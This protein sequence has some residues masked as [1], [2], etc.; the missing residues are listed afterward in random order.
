[1]RKEWTKE[2]DKYILENYQ[3]STILKMSEHLN[4][5]KSSVQHRMH[6]LGVRYRSKH[7]WTAEDDRYIKHKIW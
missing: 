5:T 4:R 6:K 1:M 3:K 7:Y 2:E